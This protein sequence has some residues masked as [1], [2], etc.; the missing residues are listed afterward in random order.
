MNNIKLY[1][2]DTIIIKLERGWLKKLHEAVKNFPPHPTHIPA[3]KVAVLELR[4]SAK[5]VIVNK[6]WC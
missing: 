1:T 4:Y 5:T 6:R 3:G 2:D